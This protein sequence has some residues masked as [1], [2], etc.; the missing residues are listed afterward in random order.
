MLALIVGAALP[1]GAPVVAEGC[2][3]FLR[4]QWRRVPEVALMLKQAVEKHSGKTYE[5]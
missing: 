4:L 5:P 2:G 1:Q 3:D